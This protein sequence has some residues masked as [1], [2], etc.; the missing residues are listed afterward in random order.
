MSEHQRHP[1]LKECYNA[2]CGGVYKAKVGEDWVGGLPD[3]PEERARFES[4]MK[5]HCW[6]F[7]RYDD[8]LKSYDTVPARML[9]GVWRDRGSLPTIFPNV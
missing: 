6:D 8:S 7:G 2:G 3:T 5:G 1:T 4:Y 9:Y